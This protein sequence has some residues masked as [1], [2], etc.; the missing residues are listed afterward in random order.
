MVTRVRAERMGLG[1][2]EKAPPKGLIPNQWLCVCMCMCFVV[3]VCFQAIIKK[4]NI[5]IQGAKC[6]ECICLWTSV[7]HVDFRPPLSYAAHTSFTGW[8]PPMMGPHHQSKEETALYRQ[9]VVLKKAEG[10]GAPSQSSNV[11]PTLQE[12]ERGLIAFDGI[13]V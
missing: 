4:H 13:A 11:F 12:K 10:E 9:G 2:V 5:P 3:D 8:L 1:L 7:R 6:L